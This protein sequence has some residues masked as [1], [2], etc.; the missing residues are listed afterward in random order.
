MTGALRKH[1]SPKAVLHQTVLSNPVVKSVLEDTR[2]SIAQ[3]VRNI[4][5]GENAQPVAMP[6]C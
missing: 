2:S 4:V 6:R 5:A 3:T 1:V